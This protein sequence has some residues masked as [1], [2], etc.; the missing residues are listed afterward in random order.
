MNH[1]RSEGTFILGSY[2][3]VEEVTE[4]KSNPAFKNSVAKNILDLRYANENLMQQIFKTKIFKL[5]D[6]FFKK[7][8]K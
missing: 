2:Y 5:L 3:S 8:V 7:I 1:E 6:K 4:I